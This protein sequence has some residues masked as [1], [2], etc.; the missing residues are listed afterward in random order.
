MFAVYDCIMDY[1]FQGSEWTEK[2]KE[3]FR[4]HPE[5]EKKR[6]GIKVEAIKLTLNKCYPP[7]SFPCIV[8]I[9]LLLYERN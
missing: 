6:L 9:Q 3:V 4:K 2:E 5:L 7:A 1:L 8:P